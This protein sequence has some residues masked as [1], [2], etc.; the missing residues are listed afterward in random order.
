MIFTPITTLYQNDSLFYRP[1]GVVHYV[2]PKDEIYCF[3]STKK[4]VRYYLDCGLEDDNIR[5]YTARKD[6]LFSIHHIKRK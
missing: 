3:Y 4:S 6:V 5:N 2:M 1:T